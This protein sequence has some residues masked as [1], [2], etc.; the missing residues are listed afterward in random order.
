M[1]NSSILKIFIKISSSDL[2]KVRRIWE[3][4]SQIWKKFAELEKSSSILEK[5][6]WI[7]ERSSNEEE[8]KK[9]NRKMKN[10]K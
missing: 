10:K 1:K 4:E 9:L 2:E 8:G 6:G 3:N 5:C 7:W